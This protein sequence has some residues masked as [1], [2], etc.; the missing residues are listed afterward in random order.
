MIDREHKM[1]IARQAEA[2][3]IS[4]AGVYCLPRPVSGRDLKLMRRM[5]ELHMDDPSRGRAC[6]AGC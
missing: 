3:K 1:P 2:V 6:C 5:D 4:R